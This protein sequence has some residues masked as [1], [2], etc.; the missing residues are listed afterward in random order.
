MIEYVDHEHFFST[1]SPQEC[2]GQNAIIEAQ[3]ALQNKTKQREQNRRKISVRQTDQNNRYVRYVRQL[4]F[5]S[6]GSFERN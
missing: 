4:F 6:F 3:T 2:V 5:G 1:R